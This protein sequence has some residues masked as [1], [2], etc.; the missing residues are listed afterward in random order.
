MKQVCLNIA[1]VAVLAVSVGALPRAASADVMVENQALQSGLFVKED[2]KPEG[3]EGFNECA[4]LADVHY[5]VLSGMTNVEKQKQLNADFLVAAEK[6]RCEGKESSIESKDEPASSTYNFEVTYQS[7]SL[8]GI[9]HE[10]WAYT[11]GAHGNGAIAGSIIDLDQGKILTMA[12]LFAGKDLPA[13]NSY[14]HDVLSAEPEGEVFHDAIESFK[15]EFVTEKEC[16]NCAVLLTEEGVKVVFQTYAVASFANGPME[17]LI[18]DKFIAYSSVQKA[19]KTV[20]P[21]TPTPEIP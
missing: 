21:A 2:C 12:E 3:M 20:K 5:P 1:L 9:R 4:C 13:V 18:P 17:V 15:G 6:Q 7:A 14:I 10:S 8:L 19:P 11:G 16:K